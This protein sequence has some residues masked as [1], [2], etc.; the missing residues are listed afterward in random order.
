M[1]ALSW[2]LPRKYVLWSQILITALFVLYESP[3]SFALLSAIT[4]GNYYLLHHAKLT[5]SL[6]IGISL[7]VLILLIGVAKIVFTLSTNWLLPLG[8]SYYIFRN[9]HY[10]LEYYKGK[11]RHE[12]LSFYLAYNFFLPVFLIGPINR[13][14]DFVRDWQRRRFN[15]DYFSMG[16][17]RLLFGTAKIFILGNYIFTYKASLYLFK[18]PASYLWL[19]TYLESLRFILNAYF[20]FAGYSDI[21]IGFGL[22]MGYRIN[23]NFNNPF[24]AT[25]MRE[26]WTKYHMSLSSF[27]SDYIYSPI[28]SYFRKP[29]I[30][31]VATM[32]IIGLWHQIN[33]QYLIWGFIQAIAIYGSSY[34]PNKSKSIVL[35]Y[36]GRLFVFN[37]FAI[38]CIL[39]SH[40]T[41][42]HAIEKYK[43]LFFI[44]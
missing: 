8:M 36:L 3:I 37:F 29:T 5:D 21:A 17:E 6:K 7:L 43:I 31:I 28:A 44:Q 42:A 10:S 35:A 24:W 40:D 14:P 39:V 19:S 22:L 30:G 41:F 34:F 26:F 33:F 38:S 27:C 1:I 11:I 12:P 4:L 25:N 2:I 13:Y 23:E 16:L 32:M 9:I 15:A 20:Q 18:I